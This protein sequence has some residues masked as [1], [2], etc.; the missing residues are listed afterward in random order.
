MKSKE[1]KKK[2]KTLDEKLESGEISK[3]WHDHENLVRLGREK[4]NFSTR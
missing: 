4:A 1:F 2:E 3:I